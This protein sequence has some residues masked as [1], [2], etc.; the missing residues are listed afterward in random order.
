MKQNKIIKSIKLLSENKYNIYFNFLYDFVEHHK[1][2]KLF[3]DNLFHMFQTQ[4]I[5]LISYVSMIHELIC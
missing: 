1:N 4:A 3:L 5:Y 2:F